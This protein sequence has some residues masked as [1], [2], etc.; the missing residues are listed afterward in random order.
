[1]ELRARELGQQNENTSS[2][3]LERPIGDVDYEVERPVGPN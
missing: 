1:V 2:P 3:E